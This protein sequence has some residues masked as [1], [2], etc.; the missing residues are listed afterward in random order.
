MSFR[1]ERNVWTV[2]KSDVG[3]YSW[4]HLDISHDLTKV[5]LET[6]PLF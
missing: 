5:H 2:C 6:K 4:L 1:T 3:E